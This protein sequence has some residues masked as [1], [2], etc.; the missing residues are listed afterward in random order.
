MLAQRNVVAGSRPAVNARIAAISRPQ[1]ASRSVVAVKAMKVGEA[2]KDSAEYYRVLKT[3]EGKTVTLASF[4][5][6]PL[7]LFFYPK[8]A[9]PGCTKEA[10]KFRDEYSA[11]TEAGAA[12]FGISSDSPAEN[13]AWADANRLPFPLLTDPSSILRKT[14]GIKGD[15]LGLLPGRQTFVFNKAGKCVLSFNDQMN[16]EQHVAE[17]LKALKA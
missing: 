6:K 17:A 7:V 8:A 5:G 9:T 10:C 16:A 12:V 14:F 15:L 3:S 1:R 2:L 4:E 13:K 11:F